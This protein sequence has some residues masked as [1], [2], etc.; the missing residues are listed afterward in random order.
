MRIEIRRAAPE[1]AAALT[2]ISHAAKRHWGYPEHWIQH[3][4]ADLTITPEF[5]MQNDVHVATNQEE[6]LGFYALLIANGQAELEHMW[7]KPEHIG[8]GI[9]KELFVHAMQRAASLSVTAVGITADPNAEG[10][11]QHL[12]AARVGTA[13]SEIDG[14]P[15]LLPRLEIDPNPS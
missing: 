3:W 8:V 15:R 11:Y 1:D 2:Q 12:G 10:F 14:K 5:I 6:I 9:G 7:V 4:S 13:E